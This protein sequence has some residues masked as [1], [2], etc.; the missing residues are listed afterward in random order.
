[1]HARKRANNTTSMHQQTGEREHAQQSFTHMMY[2]V[3]QVMHALQLEVV[4]VG[5]SAIL[6]CMPE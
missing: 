2:C 3:Q 4:A 6:L 5:H 1:V